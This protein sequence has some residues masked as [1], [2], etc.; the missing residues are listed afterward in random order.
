MAIQCRAVKNSL[1]GTV[2]EMSFCRCRLQLCDQW[3]E[4]FIYF[5]LARKI[6]SM[7][8]FTKIVIT[9]RCL[10]FSVEFCHFSCILSV[11]G[12]QFCVYVCRVSL[13]VVDVGSWLSGVGSWLS[14][15]G[16]WLQG[17][18]CQ[19][20]AVECWCR[21]SLNFFPC[22]CPALLIIAKIY[23]YT[24]ILK[25]INLYKKKKGYLCSL[26]WRERCELS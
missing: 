12:C 25:Y 2:M 7:V 21:L 26:L 6:E 5:I 13:S 23:M 16:S 20:L 15:D 11:V 14:G 1:R 17:V 18:V 24:F 8:I 10:P 3:K 22:W 4:N 19:V 9:G